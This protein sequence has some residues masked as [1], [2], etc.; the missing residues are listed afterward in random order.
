MQQHIFDPLG[1]TSSSVDKDV[2]GLAT[3]YGG[4]MPD[5]SRA[6]MPFVDARAMAAATGI[7]S[8]VDDMAKFVS[9][10]FCDGKVGGRQ[11]LSIGALRQMHRVRVL[12]NNWQSGNAIGFAVSREGEKIYV[13]HGG[14]YFGY[15]TQTLMQMEPKVRRDCSDQCR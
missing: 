14:S 7:T 9:S 13:G 8:N 4:R 2:E 12:E 15:K 6:K 10:Q 5:G 1:M 11:I 3:G